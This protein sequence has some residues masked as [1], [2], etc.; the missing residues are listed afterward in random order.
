MKAKAK[1]K[2]EVKFSKIILMCATHISAVE[3][4]NQSV[5]IIKSE[6]RYGFK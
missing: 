6:L 1:K 4:K 2:G 5:S 3:R